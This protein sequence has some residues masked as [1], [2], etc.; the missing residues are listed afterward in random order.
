MAASS[1][2]AVGA[3]FCSTGF[4]LLHANVDHSDT[5]QTSIVFRCITFSSMAAEA[6]L[7]T[8]SLYDVA[9]DRFQPVTRKVALQRQCVGS[10]VV[11]IL[12]R[13]RSIATGR[14]QKQ[15]RDNSHRQE[16][17]SDNLG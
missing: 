11:E 12:F 13:L 15:K 6:A 9:A 1:A 8:W 16:E 10:D 17:R 7:Q 5:A 4:S 2:E 14:E 3:S